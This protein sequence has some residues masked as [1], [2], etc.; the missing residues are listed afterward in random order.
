ML[1]WQE[2]QDLAPQLAVARDKLEKFERQTL[3]RRVIERL[4]STRPFH[5]F[6]LLRS[7]SLFST[8]V[9][10]VAAIGVMLVSLIERDF[11][12]IVSRLEAAAVIPLPIAL[13]ML[14]VCGLLFAL[15]AHL[16]LLV[17][18][19]SAPLLPHEA[20]QHQRL[21][22]DVKRLEATMAVQARLTPAPADPRVQTHPY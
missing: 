19:R 5:P 1:T 14:A 6:L 17:L 7:L 18:G 21:V 12:V 8:I 9:F 2:R 22:S 10:G 16:A 3:N 4:R 15:C 11:A 13:A 20:R